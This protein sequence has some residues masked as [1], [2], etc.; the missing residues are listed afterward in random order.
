MPLAISPFCR[1]LLPLT[2]P[3]QLFAIIFSHD[4]H[5]YTITLTFSC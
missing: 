3:S 1:L 4:F 2:P 5:A